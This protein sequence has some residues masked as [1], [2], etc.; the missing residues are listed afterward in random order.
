METSLHRQLKQYYAAPTAELEVRIGD[1]RIDV[2]SGD[3]LVEIQHG[4]LASIREKVRT[5]LEDHR[6]L[7]VKPIVTRR[8]LVKRDRKGGR[9]I[10]R[11]LSPKRGTLLLLFE[12]LVY[13]TRVFP[14]PNLTLEVPM[15]AVEEWRY[16]GHGRR[17]RH[18][19]RDHQVEDQ[20]LVEIEAVHSFRTA[21]DLRRLIPQPLPSPFHTLHLAEAMKVERW[22]AQKIAYCLR[23][24][25]AVTPI[26][27][28]GNAWLYEFSGKKRAVA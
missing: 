10:D 26:G 5:L 27:K 25:G 17:R 6:M 4:S 13:F 21:S 20:R 2:V 22:L 11:R 24:A 23:N 18:R 19:P 3:Q 8:H 15:V 14:H 16:P 9:V 1:F 28:K 12:V 7:V